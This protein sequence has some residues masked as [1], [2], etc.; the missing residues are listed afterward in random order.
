[1]N[2]VMVGKVPVTKATVDMTVFTP[3]MGLTALIGMKN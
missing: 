2:A 1:M 3:M